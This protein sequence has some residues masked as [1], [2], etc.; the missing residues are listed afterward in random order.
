MQNTL[1][2]NE[3]IQIDSP[4][5]GRRVGFIGKFKNR[6]ALVKKVKEIGASE[7]SKD[8]LTRDTQ[9]LVI[10]DDVKQSLMNRLTCYEHDG[11]HP[12][13]ITEKDLQ[14]IIEG[15]YEGYE[16]P[17]KPIKCISID[18]S[19]YNWEPPKLEEEDDENKESKE[20]KGTVRKA[21]PLNYEDK[22]NFLY[23]T[24]MYVPNIKKVNMNVFRQIAGNLGCFASA[25]F[26]DDTNIILLSDETLKKLRNGIKDDTINYIETKYNKSM[27]PMFNIQFTCET[28]FINWVK[29]RLEMYPDKVTQGLVDVYLK[30]KVSI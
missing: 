23:G 9:I 15:H 26:S 25:L 24:E 14:N 30:E 18:M 22:F 13:K 11:W 20:I 28:D 12:L 21:S 10:G 4:L 1:F 8:G 19:Y 3:A 5:V 6:A 29:K 27:S 17:E 7:K 2:D 16:T